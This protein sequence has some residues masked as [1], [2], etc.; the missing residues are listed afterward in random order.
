MDPYDSF[1]DLEQRLRAGDQHAATEVFR[2]FEN[3]LIA[4]ARSELDA[5]VR[6]KEDP[7]D[8]V[9]SVYGSFFRRHHDG[10]FDLGTW[11]SLWSLLTVITVRKCLNRARRYRSQR[12]NVAGEVDLVT[13]DGAADGLCEAIDREPT[14]LEAV[15]LRETVEQMMRGLDA[16]DRAII[17]LNLQG[18]SAAEIAAQLGRSERTVRRVRERVKERLRRIQAA[19]AL[20]T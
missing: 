7:E 19:G 18:F 13:F 10:Q 5:Q 15:V 1:A 3:R 14:P 20:V 12:R 11:D 6:R 17:E 8:V 2:R 4:L 16:D 9:Q